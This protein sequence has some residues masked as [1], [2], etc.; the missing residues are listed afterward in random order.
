MRPVIIDLHLSFNSRYF[1]HAS[2]S[3]FVKDFI[4]R[5]SATRTCSCFSYVH[6]SVGAGCALNP[7]L[8]TNERKA[9]SIRAWSFSHARTNHEN[10]STAAQMPRCAINTKISP[11]SQSYTTYC[12]VVSKME[13]RSKR[14]LQAFP[15][16][17]WSMGLD[18]H[19]YAFR[20]GRLVLHLYCFVLVC[21]IW[22]ISFNHR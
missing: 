3:G 20:P 4:P 16:R 10:T 13:G 17:T 11:K 9:G 18:R 22:R 14:W 7:T 8:I 21:D 6:L 19:Y 5:A 15:V 12:I 2:I 1:F